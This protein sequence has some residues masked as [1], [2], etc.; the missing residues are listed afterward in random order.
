MIENN[1]EYYPYILK[2]LWR[3]NH[4]L[5]K[6]TLIKKLNMAGIPFTGGY[7]RMMHEN[8]IFSK[9]I[10]YKNG[11]PYFCSKNKKI[12]KKYGK[13]TLPISER[14]NKDF[15]W[16]KFIHPPNKKIQMDYIISNFK[17]I[18]GDI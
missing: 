10:A 7:E 15:I 18:L 13:G 8:P 9:M 14:I 5:D 11:C 4:I 3:G 12:S 16:F 6:K 17:K 1:T 2:F